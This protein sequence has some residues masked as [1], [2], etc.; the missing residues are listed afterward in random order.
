VDRDTASL[1]ALVLGAGCV[2]LPSCEPAWDALADSARNEFPSDAGVG[3]PRLS[4]SPSCRSPARRCATFGDER[5]GRLSEHSAVYDPEQRSMLVFGGTPS[6]H[7]NCA[8]SEVTFLDDL[9]AYDDRCGRWRRSDSTGPSPRARHMAAFGDG[10]M[11][12]FGGR[13]RAGT[14]GYYQLYYDLWTYDPQSDTWREMPTP[15]QRPTAR[16][17]GTL[18]YDDARSSLWLMGGNQ[19]EHGNNYLP[20]NDVWS[21]SAVEERWEQHNTSVGPAPRFFH[22]SA[23]DSSR[24]RLVVFGG[25]DA[26]TISAGTGY[27]RDLWA[28]GL[29]SLDWEELSDGSG[30]PAGRFSPQLVFETSS[31]AYLLFGGHDDG[32]LGNRNDTWSFDPTNE[33]WSA[34]AGE[35]SLLSGAADACEDSADLAEVDPSLPERRHSH[36]VVWS[37]PCQHALLFAG[38]TDCGSADDLW[39]WAATGWNERDPARE[40]E[41]CRRASKAPETCSEL[42][43]P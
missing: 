38:K 40:G 16:I 6:V 31:A 32:D 17:N 10:R 9:W 1:L 18:V 2:A 30:G 19:S 35:D 3:D 7:V 41:V 26:A 5:P 23:L 22:A 43:S 24:D 29:E 34:V 13:F 15:G 37:T 12:V 33:R 27:F 39:R 4:G 21:Y 14:S 11:W 20:T 36:T 25:A 8:P 42:C 28:L